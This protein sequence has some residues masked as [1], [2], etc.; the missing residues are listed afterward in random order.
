MG[1]A[2]ISLE[3]GNRRDFMSGFGAGKAVNLRNQVGKDEG[4]G[5]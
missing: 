5:Y 4:G 1:D 2:W 3:K